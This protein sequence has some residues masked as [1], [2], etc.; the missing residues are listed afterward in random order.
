VQRAGSDDAEIDLSH[1]V[2]GTAQAMFKLKLPSKKPPGRPSAP[3]PVAQQTIHAEEEEEEVEEMSDDEDLYC[4]V[5]TTVKPERQRSKQGGIIM[6]DMYV[7]SQQHDVL[8]SMPQEVTS[9]FKRARTIKQ[10]GAAGRAAA[11]GGGIEGE[12]ANLI[13][14]FQDGV[15]GADRKAEAELLRQLLQRSQGRQRLDIG[16]WLKEQVIASSMDSKGAHIGDLFMSL[17]QLEDYNP[18]PA[19]VPPRGIAVC[20]C[21][22]NGLAQSLGSMCRTMDATFEYLAH[23][24]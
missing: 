9:A 15:S 13:S 18:P 22:P 23:A 24:D 20:F 5:S 7:S 19:G 4:V 14:R 16:A 17:I 1:N 8:H 21:G 12:L 3:K 10:G 11:E 2:Y 6:E